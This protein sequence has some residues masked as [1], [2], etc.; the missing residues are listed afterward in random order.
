MSPIKIQYDL[1]QG[2]NPQRE[3]RLRKICFEFLRGLTFSC[4]YFTRREEKIRII[5]KFS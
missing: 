2:E 5:W 4:G 3:D 1:P